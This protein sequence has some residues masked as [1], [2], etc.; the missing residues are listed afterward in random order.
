MHWDRTKAIWT[1]AASA[2]GKQPS[3]S[4]DVARMI[5]ACENGCLGDQLIQVARF[6]HHS[7]QA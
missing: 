1:T 7:W 3:V 2:A 4:Q 6:F 5:A